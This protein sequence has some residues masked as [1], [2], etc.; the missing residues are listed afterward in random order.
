MR[1]AGAIMGLISI[2]FVF[3]L[4]LPFA[5]NADPTVVIDQ[6]NITY[7]KE[8]PKYNDTIT[9]TAPVLAV[10]AD[11]VK[12]ELIWML[13]IEDQ[14]YLPTTVEMTDDGS[15]NYQKTIG[16]FD[17]RDE[18]DELYKDVGVTVKVTY[19]ATGG[20]DE[21]TTESELIEINFDQT[22]A[23][24]PDSDTDSDTDDDDGDD[25]PF[26]LEIAFIGAA[27]AIGIF[28]FKR[29]KE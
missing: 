11:I 25:S 9:I 17:A 14:C 13:C 6:E 16:P 21:M 20:G 28:A 15:G 8:I 3:S 19:T 5:V 10:D 1:T 26:G 12:V 4:V 2:V 23:P 18:N 29:K 24:S 7:D 22:S 27:I